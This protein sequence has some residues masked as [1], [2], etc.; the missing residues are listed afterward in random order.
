MGVSSEGKILCNSVLGLDCRGAEFADLIEDEFGTEEIFK[1]TGCLPGTFFS[2][3]KIAWIKK[4]E[5]AL[6]EKTSYFFYMG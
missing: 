1:I 6:Y 3:P 2:M 4:Y 5:P